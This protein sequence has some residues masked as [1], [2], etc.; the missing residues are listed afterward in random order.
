L[1]VGPY[2]SGSVTGR[3]PNS[4]LLVRPSVIRPASRKCATRLESF[5]PSGGVARAAWLPDVTGSPATVGPEIL[6]QE[7]DAGEGA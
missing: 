5:L 2:A 4:G 7:R 1:R 3:L 6:E